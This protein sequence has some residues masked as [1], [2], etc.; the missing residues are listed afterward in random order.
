MAAIDAILVG[1]GSRGTFIYGGYARDHRDRL[2]FVAVA[3]PSQA[4]RVRFARLH[5]LPDERCFTSWEDAIAAGIAAQVVVVATMDTL[6]VAPSVEAMRSGYHVLLEKPMAVRPED[7]IQLVEASKRHDRMLQI[8]HVLRHTAFFSRLKQLVSSGLLGQ[9]VSIQHQENVTYWHMAHSFVRGNWG[10]AEFSGPMILTKCCHDIDLLLWMMSHTK[11]VSV[12]SIGALTHF[13]RENAPPGATPRCTDG[14]PAES[15][16]P[17]SAPRVYLD[18]KRDPYFAA[19]LTSDVSYEGRLK[20][21]KEGPYGKC[22]YMTDNDVVDH[23][24][25]VIEF[26]DGATATL[27]LQGFSATEGRTMRYD[28]SHATIRGAFPHDGD[29]ELEIQHHF[30]KDSELITVANAGWGGHGGGDGGLITS[31][32]DDVKANERSERLCSVETALMSHL[33]AFAAEESRVTR[34]TIQIADYIAQLKHSS[35]L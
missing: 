30:A 35:A 31:F 18:M 29:R 21:L 2:R 8:G 34:Q 19:A 16:C 13:T 5:D 15:D 28:G 10:R 27:I 23:Q 11:P 1:A 20:A 6:H 24:T 12:T 7:C 22:V 3:E 25:V 17:F 32:L 33:V 26:A 14:C 9:I 4:R